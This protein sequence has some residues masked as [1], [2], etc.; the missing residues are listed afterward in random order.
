[1]VPE[2]TAITHLKFGCGAMKPANLS[3]NLAACLMNKASRLWCLLQPLVAVHITELGKGLKENKPI[4]ILDWEILVFFLY[5]WSH[6]IALLLDKNNF[7]HEW[8]TESGLRELPIYSGI[9][10]CCK[11]PPPSDYL[12]LNESLSCVSLSPF[13]FRLS[14]LLN[15][16][17]ISPPLFFSID[18]NTMTSRTSPCVDVHIW[19][20]LLLQLLSSHLVWMLVLELQLMQKKEREAE[21]KSPLMYHE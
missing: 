21:K 11:L 20:F 7:L 13:F 8:Q 2:F 10:R 19:S 12:V 16:V 3:A 6:A 4:L 17:S 9:T 18:L 1:M 5:G 15:L 14:H